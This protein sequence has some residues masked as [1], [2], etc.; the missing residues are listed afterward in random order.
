MSLINKYV[1]IKETLNTIYKAVSYIPRLPKENYTQITTALLND[2]SAAVKEI[3]L[4]LL[5]NARVNF[6]NADYLEGKITDYEHKD[7]LVEQYVLWHSTILEVL[8]RQYN[9][10]NSCDAKFMRLMDYIRFID[11]E[12][13]VENAKASL[14]RDRKSTRLNSSHIH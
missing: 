13:I 5:D 7:I 10:Q 6:C 8:E 9:A 14:H 12:S 3:N 11:F 4:E 1:Q 2:L